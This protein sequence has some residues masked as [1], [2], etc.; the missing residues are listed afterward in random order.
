MPTIAQ[1]VHINDRACPRGRLGDGLYED[2]A[3]A[4]DK[5]IAGSGTEAIFLYQRP[6][7]SQ[8]LE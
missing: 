2:T 3:T 6:I 7:I 8:H 1:A 4:T 5:K